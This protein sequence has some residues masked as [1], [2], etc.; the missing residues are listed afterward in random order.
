M[1]DTDDLREREVI[2]PDGKGTLF[3]LDDKDAPGQATVM[4]HIGKAWHASIP[5]REKDRF[6]YLDS[7]KA[8]K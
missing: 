1:L 2:T 3:G 5:M 4:L 8:E 6:V 7:K